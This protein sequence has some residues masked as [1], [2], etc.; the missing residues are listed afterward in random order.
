MV[1]P[2]AQYR[3]TYVFPAPANYQ[4]S[5]AVVTAP[6]GTLLALDGVPVSASPTPVA[7]T[8]YGVVR[9]ALQSTSSAAHQL[10]ASAP[11]SVQVMGYGSY[12]S[13]QYPAGLDLGLIAPAPAK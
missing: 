9:L 13:Y 2:V 4:A 12:T 10:I 8:T 1:V 6:L 3:P 7:G 5:F 11:V